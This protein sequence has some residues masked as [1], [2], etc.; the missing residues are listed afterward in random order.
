MRGLRE[1]LAVR[2]EAIAAEENAE[3]ED[4]DTLRADLNALLVR[5]AGVL[6][7][8][9]KGSG[10]LRGRTAQRLAREAMFFCVWS[11]QNPVR[12]GT[13]DRLLGEQG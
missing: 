6:M 8:I 9:A 13:I 3:K 7:T 5:L 12:E 2:L 11:A 1:A 4:I 10:Y